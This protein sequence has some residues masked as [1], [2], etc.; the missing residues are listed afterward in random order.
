[1]YKTKD[2]L[3]FVLDIIRTKANDTQY[4][5]ID[6]DKYIIGNANKKDKVVSFHTIKL[7]HLVLNNL[8][9]LDPLKYMMKNIYLILMIMSD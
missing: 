2:K 8:C 5:Y 1:M 9:G 7:D 6:L 3:Q 4:G